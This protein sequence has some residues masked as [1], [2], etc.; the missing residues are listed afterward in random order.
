M[1]YST[2]MEYLFDAADLT[3]LGAHGSAIT[4]MARQLTPNSV[5]GVIVRASSLASI[6]ISG[7]ELWHTYCLAFNTTEKRLYYWSGTSW[8]KLPAALAGEITNAMLGLNCVELDNLWTPGVA[9]NGKIL[10]VN[11]SGAF[12]LI[13]IPNAIAVNTLPVSRLIYGSAD[14]FLQTPNPAGAPVWTAIDLTY[15]LTKLVAGAIPIDR[16]ASGT[17]G[18]FLRTSGGVPVWGDFL[19]ASDITDQEISTSKISR[20]GGSAGKL[21][22]INSTN[23]DLEYVTAAAIEPTIVWKQSV[24]YGLTVDQVITKPTGTTWKSIEI[25]VIAQFDCTGAANSVTCNLTYQPSGTAIPGTDGVGNP[26]HLFYIANTDDLVQ[27]HWF[28]KA[29]VNIGE[30]STDSITIR[31]AL[32]LGADVLQVAGSGYCFAIKAT[33]A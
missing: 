29:A 13:T 8:V 30:A 23:T 28:A 26:G 24:T 32:V 22:R 9:E 33:Y 7:T 14:T 12:A 18:Y 3:S 17:D 25:D 5:H 1:P 4:N 27:M 20:V 6:P 11:G 10:Q 31:A 19:P 21:L 2:L 15:L 16:L